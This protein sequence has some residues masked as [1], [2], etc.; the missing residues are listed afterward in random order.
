LQK[1]GWNLS[2]V[3]SDLCSERYRALSQICI[4]TLEVQRWMTR[5][6]ERKFDLRSPELRTKIL[7]SYSDLAAPIETK[8]HQV[9]WQLVLNELDQLNAIA[10]TAAR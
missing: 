1:P 5:L 9:C 7:Q 6:T 4:D 10:Q 3:L 2:R 8:K